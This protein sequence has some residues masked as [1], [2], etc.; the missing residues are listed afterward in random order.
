[1]TNKQ[2]V[3]HRILTLPEKFK[4]LGNQTFNN[5]EADGFGLGADLNPSIGIGL[6]GNI[7]PHF[8]QFQQILPLQYH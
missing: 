1:M 4:S 6:Y 3:I 7:L 8:I 5:F 2:E